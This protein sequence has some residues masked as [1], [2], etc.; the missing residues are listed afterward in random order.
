M[1]TGTIFN[2][3][4]NSGFDVA[5][6]VPDAVSRPLFMVVNSFDKGPEK[7]MEVD[8]TNFNALFGKMSYDKHGQ[9]SIQAQ[10]IIDAGGRLLVKRVCANDSGL[11]N[12][13]L[14]A[15]LESDGSLSYTIKPVK[16]VTVSSGSGTVTRAPKTFAEVK[17]A[18]KDMLVEGDD[19]TEYPLFVI[20]DNGRG[21]SDKAVRIIP[22]YDTARGLN[23]MIYRFNVYEGT[24]LLENSNISLDPTYIF[25]NEYY[26][27]DKNR[28]T[29]VTGEVIPEIYEQFV[30]DVTRKYVFAGTDEAKITEDLIDIVKSYDLIFGYTYKCDKIYKLELDENGKVV[31]D[32]STVAIKQ[33]LD[34][35]NNPVV[36]HPVYDNEDGSLLYIEFADLNEPYGNDFIYGG[37]N[38]SYGETPAKFGNEHDIYSFYGSDEA[39]YAEPNFIQAYPVTATDDNKDFVAYLNW[40]VDIARV[41][42]GKDV[43]GSDIDEVWDVDSH[44]IFAVADA[45]YPKFVKDC[46]ANF[47][48]FRKDCILLRDCG[49]GA[50]DV[51]KAGDLYDKYILDKSIYLDRSEFAAIATN[52]GVEAEIINEVNSDLRSKFFADYGTTYEIVDP[53]TKKNIR[54]TMIYD[55]VEDLT[56]RYLT[57]GPFAPVAGTYNGFELASAISGTVNFVPIIT[58]TTNQKQAIDD[59]RLN[60]AIFEDG[61]LCVV[62]SNYTSQDKN[63]QLSF[64]NNVLAIQ[65]VARVVRT[66]CPR[67]RFSLITGSDMSEY[68]TAV[69]RVLEG[70]TSY[71]ETLQFQYTQ[72]PLRSIQKIFYASINFSFNNW[73]QT[74]IFDLYALA[75]TTTTSIN[76]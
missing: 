13:V 18:A 33:K 45:N 8:A 36:P 17:K 43:D 10:K 7:L 34:D 75:N 66:A 65:E 61:D 41:Y 20:T 72:D 40:T 22:D 58:P 54:V 67:N 9:G 5:T 29:Q 12:L 25:N 57:S 73:A 16:E 2:W 42:L 53:G 38:G 21:I 62:Q 30:E 69:S 14:V 6:N 3:Y 47:V 11:A 46:M 56:V 60:Y 35:N 55:L 76:S 63:T 37:D 19:K 52:I 44:K 28:M 68:A 15:V 51:R 48:Q 27:L 39:E 24:T 59:L 71:F 74:E 4:D 64:I 26:G 49:I 50:Y 70:Y 32:T 23:Q 1:Y 31:P